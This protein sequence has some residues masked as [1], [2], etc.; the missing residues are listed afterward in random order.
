MPSWLN[1]MY[2]VVLGGRPV[3]FEPL[4]YS[5]RL[6]TGR[7]DPAHLIARIC[8]GD[9]GLVVLGYS[10]EVAARMNDGLH[11]LWPPP[12]LAALHDST[13][14][15]GMLAGRYIYT[16]TSA[17]GPGCRFQRADYAPDLL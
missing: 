1:R 6:D 5:V 14:L 9:F 4:I 7:W 15:E 10:L 3:L 17:S 2:V 16:P 13:A 11:A 8:H 12:V